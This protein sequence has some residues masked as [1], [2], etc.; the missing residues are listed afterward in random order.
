LD[1]CQGLVLR[2]LDEDLD[3]DQS[4]NRIERIEVKGSGRSK[5][6]TGDEKQLCC[7]ELGRPPIVNFTNIFPA[8]FFANILLPN[9]HKAKL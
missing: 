2:L 4:Q 6:I 1:L 9:T 8:A 5:G 7:D 3:E